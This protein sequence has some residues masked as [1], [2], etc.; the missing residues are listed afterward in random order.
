MAIVYRHRRVDNNKIFYI[1]SGDF[2]KEFVS[3][4]EARRQFG[5]QISHA[6]TGIQKTASNYL[7]SYKKN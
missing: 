2:I 5:G 6:C 7:W 3:A 4:R 1:G